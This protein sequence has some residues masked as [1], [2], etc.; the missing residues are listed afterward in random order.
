MKKEKILENGENF[1]EVKY[2]QSFPKGTA[3]WI[4]LNY[5]FVKQSMEDGIKRA[6]SSKPEYEVTGLPIEYDITLEDD[7][8]TIES[9]CYV[10][11][12]E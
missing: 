10:K 3:L 12:K 1:V 8:L 5:K 7:R 11:L 2:K 9:I 4:L 6:L